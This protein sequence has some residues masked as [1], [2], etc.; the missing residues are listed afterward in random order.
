MKIRTTIAGQPPPLSVGTGAFVLPATASASTTTHTLKF[1]AETKSSAAFSSS[2]EA[3]Q[4]TDV[5][6]AGKV[7]GYVDGKVTVEPALS[8]VLPE[9]SR[10]RLLTRRA[11]VM[12]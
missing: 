4:D 1:N 8:R 9:R 3:V 10:S 2:A 7:V 12:P 6:G 11:L 5:N